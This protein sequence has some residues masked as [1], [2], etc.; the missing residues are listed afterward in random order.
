MEGLLDMEVTSASKKEQ[1]ISETAAAIFV[2]TQDDIRRSGMTSIPELLRMVPGLEVARIDASKWA[3]SARGFNDRF[4]D[5]LLVLIDG[6][7]LYSTAQSG[8]FW[9]VQNLPLDDIDRI[10]VIRGPGATLWGAGAVNGVINIITKTSQD[11]QGA[12]LTMGGGV[13][14]R[15]F[16]GFR[17]GG[18]AGQH[19]HYR[20]YGNGFDRGPFAT[21][22]DDVLT[23]TDGWHVFQAGFRTDWQLSQRDALIVEGDAYQGD[24]HQALDLTLLAPPFSQEIATQTALIGGNVLARWTRSYS[25]RSEMSL[26]FSYAADRRDD[27]TLQTFTQWIDFEFQD[28]FALSK[29]H[30]IVWGLEYRATPST[31][32]NTFQVSF[33]PPSQTL[34]LFSGFVQ[35]EVSLVPNRLHVIAG[36]KLEHAEY[37]GFNAQPNGRLLWTPSKKQTLWG[38]VAVA[39][40]TPDRADRGLDANLASFPGPGGVPTVL[41]IFGSANTRNERVL[42]YELGYRMQPLSRFSFDLATFYNHYRDLNTNEPGTPFLAASP[43]PAHVVLPLVFSNQMHGK[44]YGAELSGAL[45]VNRSWKLDASYTWLRVFLQ[46]NPGIVNATA[47]QASENNPDHQFQV[48]SQWNLPRN[49]EFDQSIYFVSDISREQVRDYTRADLRL[50]WRPWEATE[51]SVVGQ[52]LLEPRHLEFIDDNRDLSTRDVRRVFAKISWRF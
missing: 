1:K 19:G 40:R 24:Q 21:D 31:F 39:E 49:L 17:Y 52:N 38:S 27:P 30:D 32:G 44:G 29:R 11:T 6:R 13:Q 7:S 9:E 34:S 37:T 47:T 15:G 42:A 45:Q 2:I 28:R 12:L 46:S 51:I 20:V 4:S 14:E 50:G 22:A 16:G 25:E 43:A 33:L 5:K 26:Q 41:A 35:D 23:D 36:A 8:V 10:E 48:H 3:I 18:T